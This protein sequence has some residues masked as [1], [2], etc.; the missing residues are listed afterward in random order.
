MG[1]D[2]VNR[3]AV[4][5]E[6]IPIEEVFEN[7]KC[8]RAGLTSGD[9]KDRL[10][11][12]GYNKLEDKKESKIVKFL[13]IWGLCGILCHGS[14]KLQLSWLLLLHMEGWSEEDASGLVPVDIVSIKL[15]DIVLADARLLEG[16]PLKIDQGAITKRTTAIEEMAG[17]DVLC[18]DKTGTLTQNKLTVDKN[19]IEVFAKGVDRDMVVLM[20]ARASRLENQDASDGAIVAMLSDPKEVMNFKLWIDGCPFISLIGLRPTDNEKPCEA[21]KRSPFSL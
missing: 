6:N 21:P 15:G 3:E 11:L 8:T 19:M 16:D 10:D 4:D 5:L 18:N 14:W 1:L 12:F 13:G 9:V 17:M 2:A 7:L 20:A